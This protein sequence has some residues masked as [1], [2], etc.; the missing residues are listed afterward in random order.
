M[1]VGLGPVFVCPLAENGF[2]MVEKQDGAT[3]SR[4]VQIT[5]HSDPTAPR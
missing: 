2:F 1:S 5:L 4:Y 3:V